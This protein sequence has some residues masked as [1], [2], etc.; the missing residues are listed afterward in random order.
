VLAIVRF[1][2]S[3]L[4]VVLVPGKLLFEVLLL[5]AL[6]FGVVF[7]GMLNVE[8]P[9]SRA[10]DSEAPQIGILPCDAVA[11]AYST[12]RVSSMFNPR[13]FKA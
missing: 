13:S 4:C 2:D 5:D 11:I 3:P 8:L 10:L 6:H 7:P 12:I 9:L 1:P